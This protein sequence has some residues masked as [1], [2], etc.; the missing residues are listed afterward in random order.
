[1]QEN[2][3]P[4]PNT[5]NLTQVASGSAVLWRG[6]VPPDL[7]EVEA[8]AAPD[9]CPAALRRASG[10][11]EPQAM[12]ASAALEG[13]RYRDAE[14]GATLEP[15]CGWKPVASHPLLL[16]LALPG[17]ILHAALAQNAWGSTCLLLA[18]DA[19]PKLC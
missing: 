17:E 5:Q 12:L 13:L 18:S 1:M 19:G 2:P 11:A 6:R 9:E 8:P 4:Q 10:G 16:P 3:D 7:Q 15:W 14:S